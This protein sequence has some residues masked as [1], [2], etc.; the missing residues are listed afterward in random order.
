M[1]PTDTAGVAIM[2]SH[3]LL[4]IIGAPE[5]RLTAVLFH[6][7]LHHDCAAVWVGVEEEER[8]EVIFDT[9]ADH[10]FPPGANLLQKTQTMLSKEHGILSPR[11]ASNR[12]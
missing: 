5:M 8:L 10:V 7:V 1:L 6:S 4:S 11:H 12:D 3:T 2:C 9:F